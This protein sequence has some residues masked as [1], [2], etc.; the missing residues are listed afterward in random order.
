MQHSSLL[1]HLVKLKS[2]LSKY[3]I[4]M[5]SL[6][7]SYC[8]PRMWMLKMTTKQPYKDLFLTENYHIMSSKEIVL[9][10]INSEDGAT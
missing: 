8:L 5:N 7:R 1:F 3:T 10:Q 2:I 9:R 4:V 6:H